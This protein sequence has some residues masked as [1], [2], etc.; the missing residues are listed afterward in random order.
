MI[1]GDLFALRKKPC[2]KRCE[3]LYYMIVLQ[4][5]AFILP[6]SE[7]VFLGINI[8]ACLLTAIFRLKKQEYGVYY[9]KVKVN[10]YPSKADN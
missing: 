4:H 5:L 10:G 2:H 7:Q 1:V 3:G 6:S 8:A 9:R